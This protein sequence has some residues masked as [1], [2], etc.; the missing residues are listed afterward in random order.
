MIQSVLFEREQWNIKNSK[1]WLKINGLVPMK[2]VHVTAN[3]LRYRI[4]L[5]DPSKQYY[6]VHID[7]GV[8]LVYMD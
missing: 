3:T 2:G 8:T 7:A 1:Q 5:P 6:S 4:M